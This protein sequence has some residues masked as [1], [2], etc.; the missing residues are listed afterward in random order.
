[1][2]DLI[3]RGDVLKVVKKIKKTD[4]FYAL[5]QKCVEI[6]V[7]EKAINAIPSTERKV[8]RCK[9]TQV[10]GN[11]VFDTGCGHRVQGHNFSHCPYCG[12]EIAE[13]IE[14]DKC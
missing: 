4:Y 6:I 3:A 14:G 12:K 5:N 2:K 1:M 7:I 10:A 13:A 8:D 11:H 9:F